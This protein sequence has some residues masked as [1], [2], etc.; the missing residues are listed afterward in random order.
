MTQIIQYIEEKKIELIKELLAYN[1]TAIAARDANNVA[2]HH[3]ASRTGDL[4]LLKYIFEYTQ[5]K[6]D[7][8]DPKGRTCLHYGVE[9]G[10]V[11]VVAYLTEKVG[12][13]PLEGDYQGVTPFQV[14]HEHG[15]SPITAYFEK[16]VGCRFEDMYQNPI[17]RGAFPDPSVIRVGTD[18][19]MVNSSFMYFPC[20]P[21]SHSTDLIHWKIIGHAVTDPKWAHLDGLEGGR[22]YWAPDISYYEGRFYITATLRL[23]DIGPVYRK[24]MVVSSINPE[25]PYDEPA[26]IDVDGIDPSI[27]SDDDGRR[28][29]LLNRGCRILEISKDGKEQ[30]SEPELLYYGDN[31][32]AT[33]GPHL[34]K[35]DGYYYL[36]MAEGGTGRG[37]RIS[38]ARSKELKGT[39]EP[40]P[41]NPIM[42][43]LEYESTLQC[44]GHGK[45]VMTPEGDWYMVYLCSRFLEGNYGM[46]GRETAMDPMTWTADGWPI[47]N[48]L[49]GP[50]ILQKKPYLG[51]DYEEGDVFFDTFDQRILNKNWM[52]SRPPVDGEVVVKNGILSLKGSRYDLNSIRSKNAVLLRQS[53]FSFDAMTSMKDIALEIGQEVGM[54]CYYDENTY[55]K[56]GL[57]NEGSDEYCLKII[58][59][60]GDLEKVSFSRIIPV[61]ETMYIKIVVRGLCRSFYYSVDNQYF[62]LLGELE[63]VTYLCSEG[64]K[65]GKRFTGATVGLYAYEGV[66]GKAFEAKFDFF[67]YEAFDSVEGATHV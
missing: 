8:K 4:K 66:S 51:Q 50:S 64:H 29:M 47:V 22:G 18:Y 46:L 54:T 49:K 43:Q 32:H 61:V 63:E 20:I 31:K 30:L 24:Q 13:S 2:A 56:F 28:Y 11:E 10:S 37:H 39:Y 21:I 67:K 16:K 17:R 38:V 33:E 23:N 34:L 40:C 3:I 58:E 27:F 42:Q 59:R 35:K 52:F 57:F 15:T 45:P 55:L 62:E 48:E 6:I 14:A 19:Y 9:S 25:G 60:I 65:Q 44:C 41:Y 26:F 36:F 53:H 12:F 5:A 1:P 7:E